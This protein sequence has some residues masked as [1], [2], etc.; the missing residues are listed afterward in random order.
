MTKSRKTTRK[1]VAKKKTVAKK[2][3]AKKSTKTFYVVD[4]KGHKTSLKLV[5]TK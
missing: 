4:A 1:P 5:A 3:T 2:S